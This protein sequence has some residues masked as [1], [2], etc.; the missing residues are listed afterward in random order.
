M[1]QYENKYIETKMKHQTMRNTNINHFFNQ[2]ASSRD[3]SGGYHKW[4]L[5]ALPIGPYP[6]FY[7]HMFA[8]L[9]TLY[10]TPRASPS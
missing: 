7:E 9:K 5:F 2:H 10:R 8:G 4:R 3:A 6:M 1:K